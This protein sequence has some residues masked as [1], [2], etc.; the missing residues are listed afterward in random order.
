[1]ALR[2]LLLSESVQQAMLAKAEVTLSKISFD[3][4]KRNWTFIVGD[5]LKLVAISRNEFQKVDSNAMAPVS[6]ISHQEVNYEE[7][8]YEEAK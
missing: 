4:N 3:G 8:N 1:M 6:K 7:V 2:Q 5:P